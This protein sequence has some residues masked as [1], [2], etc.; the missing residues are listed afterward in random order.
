MNPS[1]YEGLPPEKEEKE[2]MKYKKF[3]TECAEELIRN[4]RVSIQKRKLTNFQSKLRTERKE[5]NKLRILDELIEENI[6]Y[7]NAKLSSRFSSQ[8]SKITGPDEISDMDD[9]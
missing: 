3:L 2:F 1:Q 5:D 8:P 4:H 6:L 9:T 7:F